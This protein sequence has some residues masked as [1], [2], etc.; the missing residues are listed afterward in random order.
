MRQ[1][2]IDCLNAKLEFATPAIS[3]SCILLGAM[4]FA[5][6]FSAEGQ[7]PKKVP[8]IAISIVGAGCSAADGEIAEE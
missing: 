3:K 6:C 5:L 2:R 4:L 7:Q 1:V 8:R